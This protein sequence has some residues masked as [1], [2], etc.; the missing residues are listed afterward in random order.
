MA[1]KRTKA[2]RSAAAKAYWAERKAREAV[3][4]APSPVPAD[5]RAALDG[6]AP[7]EVVYIAP[8]KIG[9]AVREG[10]DIFV[11]F[12]EDGSLRRERISLDLAKK[13]Y[14]DLSTIV[15]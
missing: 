11:C 15:I 3:A 14:R 6:M 10:N 13:V 9:Y 7:K 12:G 4:K 8:P 1:K 5:V 2:Q